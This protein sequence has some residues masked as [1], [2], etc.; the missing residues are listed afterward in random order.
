MTLIPDNAICSTCHGYQVAGYPGGST[1]SSRCRCEEDKVP[2]DETV[3]WILNDLEDKGGTPGQVARQARRLRVY[4]AAL[5]EP[6]TEDLIR[7]LAEAP[8]TWEEPGVAQPNDAIM[9][10]L[11]VDARQWVKMKDGNNGA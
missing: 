7:D 3:D 10:Q 9:D 6:S 8:A 2:D 11:I 4:I 1:L 5:R